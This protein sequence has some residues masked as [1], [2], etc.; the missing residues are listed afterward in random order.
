MISVLPDRLVVPLADELRGAR[1]ACTVMPDGLVPPKEG[2]IRFIG[3]NFF[4]AGIELPVTGAAY[5]SVLQF[6][7]CTGRVHGGH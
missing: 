5:E 7:R 4:T 3:G 1:V 6:P 2:D